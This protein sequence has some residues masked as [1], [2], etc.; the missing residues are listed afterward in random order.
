MNSLK[1]NKKGQTGGLITG[2]VMGVASLI[3]VAI[4]SF[5]IVQT[6]TDSNLLGDDLSD[7][8][9]VTNET[10]ASIN[11][12]GYTLSGYN[13]S[14]DSITIT[15]IWGAQGGEYNVTIPT[16]NATV[17]AGVVTN[18]TVVDNS[19]VSLS[20]TYNHVRDNMYEDSSNILVENFT[21]GVD[22]VSEQIPTVFL[23][24]AIVLVIGILALLVGVWGKMRMSG[25]E[26]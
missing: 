13:S 2:I 17:T 8:V 10:G 9:T 16:A 11:I 3:I 18:A 14:W 26:I 19:N 24:T 12:T 25:S 21:E 22:N 4:I 1:N 20:Y 15:T 6:L 5:V 7:A 23:I